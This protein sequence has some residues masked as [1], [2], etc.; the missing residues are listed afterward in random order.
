[1]DTTLHNVED[2]WLQQICLWFASTHAAMND[3]LLLESGRLTLLRRYDQ[4]LD[5]SQWESAINQ[6]LAVADWLARHGNQAISSI[7]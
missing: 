7:K 1:M 6:Q 2:R 5:S 3:A 4:G